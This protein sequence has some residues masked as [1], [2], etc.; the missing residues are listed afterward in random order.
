MVTYKLIKKYP[1][2]PELGTILREGIGRIDTED[3]I[4]TH[5]EEAKEFWE[6]QEDWEALLKEAEEKYPIGTKIKSEE[7][8]IYTVKK[9][10]VHDS[11]WCGWGSPVNV[12]YVEVESDT[13]ICGVVLYG[14]E[15]KTWYEIIEKPKAY[16]V[17]KLR[18][19][20][21]KSIAVL[22][23]DGT[24]VYQRNIG[25]GDGST[26]QSCLDTHWEIYSVERVSDGKVFTLGDRV[27]HKDDSRDCG[28]ITKFDH[29]FKMPGK[30]SKDISVV[31]TGLNYHTASTQ[32]YNY[33]NCLSV[34]RHSEGIKQYTLEEICTC[35]G[36]I[37]SGSA[38]VDVKR[39]MKELIAY[40]KT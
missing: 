40:D 14:G 9:S 24:F 17:L 30:Y 35:I 13:P 27:N 31:F 18:Y 37:G 23:F 20:E 8:V 15:K 25:Q 36:N 10:P 7:D 33:R 3:W 11:S 39:L 5:P 4:K 6:K 16:K 22:D 1:R 34:L 28:V 38:Y 19:K 21:D 2:S 29:T 32:K 26:L 12:I